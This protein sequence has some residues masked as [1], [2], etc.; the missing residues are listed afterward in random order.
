ML[1]IRVEGENK[2]TKNTEEKYKTLGGSKISGRKSK[3][4]HQTD[5][6]SNIPD[7]VGYKICCANLGF[8]KKLE[9]P[10]DSNGKDYFLELYQLFVA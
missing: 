10:L 9:A 4:S 2:I 7:P 8:V 3:R 6:L 5:R 1:Y